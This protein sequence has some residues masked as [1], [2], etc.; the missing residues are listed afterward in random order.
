MKFD[1]DALET[2]VIKIGTSLLSGQRA[3]EGHVME[4]I[5]KE[6]CALKKN[7]KINVLIVS[8]GAI[9]C[10]MN[11][12]KMTERPSALPDK[13]AVAAVGQATLMHYYETLFMTYGEGL[14][15]A[16]VLLTLRDLDL[17]DSYLN[18][19]N[20]IKNLFN[21]KRIIPIINENDS[22]AVEQLRFGDNDT[23]S[24]KIAAKLNAGLLIIFSDIDGLYAGNPQ[25]DPN[26]AHIPVV[27]E[28]T[29]DIIQY[30]GGAGTLTGTGGMRTKLDAARIAFAAGVPTII[31]NGHTPDVLH[32][33]LSGE[34]KCTLFKPAE[35]ALSHRKRWIAF[36]RTAQGTLKIDRGAR[37][38]IRT[39]GKSLLSA[40]ITDSTGHFHVGDAV[41]IRDEE[42]GLVARALV[43]YS[44]EDVRKIMGRHSNEIATILG[45]KLYDEVVHR[46]NLVLI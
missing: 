2:L 22:T 10:G 28:I 12:L 9:G 24:A 8:S 16:Q 27:D 19:R 29:P 7:H 23:L 21:M 46:D 31:T 39:H 35:S 33:V 20:T 42:G 13:Q 15:T 38:A 14:H 32:G 37:E 44:S 26:A 18:V 43:N 25:K 30:A 36:G 34:V 5:V 17:R 3:F 11:T 40:G 45:A 4:S 41:E 1:P 6:I